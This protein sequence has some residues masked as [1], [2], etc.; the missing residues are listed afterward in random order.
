MQITECFTLGRCTLSTRA[1]HFLAKNTRNTTTLRRLVGENGRTQNARLFSRIKQETQPYS[2]ANGQRDRNLNRQTDWLAFCLPRTTSSDAKSIFYPFL[3]STDHWTSS[4][5]V[6]NK[7]IWSS[8]SSAPL[9][10]SKITEQYI[11][12]LFSG[13]T[14]EGNS[15]LW[16]PRASFSIIFLYSQWHWDFVLLQNVTN[17]SAQQH[18]GAPWPG[19]IQWKKLRKIFDRHWIENREL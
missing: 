18:D 19:T 3:V 11:L 13:R 15:Y 12:L 1:L 6:W 2:Q 7:W 4:C 17:K 10:P 16:P 5:T 8:S 9:W 14:L